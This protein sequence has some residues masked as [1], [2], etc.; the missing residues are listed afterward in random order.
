MA[1]VGRSEALYRD[2]M[3]E[4]WFRDEVR[5]LRAHRAAKAEQAPVLD[6]PEFS[7]KYPFQP[8][9][10]HHL[11]I[12]D[13][14]EGRRPRDMHASI[15]FHKGRP[16]YLLA[17]MPPEHGKTTQAPDYGAGGRRRRL[18]QAL[19]GTARKAPTLIGHLP[20]LGRRPGARRGSPRAV[21]G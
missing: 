2:W 15:R 21:P 14:L 16:N 18:R 3:S 11:R 4:P 8:L 17:N 1:A 9:A 7:A 5:K 10:T 13:V 6:F 20:V 12:V 19:R